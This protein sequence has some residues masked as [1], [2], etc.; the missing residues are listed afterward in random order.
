MNSGE[1]AD[2]ADDGPARAVGDVVL[3]LCVSHGDVFLER[4][5]NQV[6]AGGGQAQ[7]VAGRLTKN[8]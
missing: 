3:V 4:T 5:D 7:R 8:V 1:K 6:V 2:R